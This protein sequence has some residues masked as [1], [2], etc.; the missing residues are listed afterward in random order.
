[1]ETSS[2]A[3]VLRKETKVHSMLL[4]LL[5][6]SAIRP[7]SYTK[8]SGERHKALAL[9]YGSPEP[10]RSVDHAAAALSWL[11]ESVLLLRHEVV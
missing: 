11:V 5:I 4:S 8:L 10:L 3:I 9:D 7:G 2:I 1:M 6:G